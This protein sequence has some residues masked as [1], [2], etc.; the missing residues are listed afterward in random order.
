MEVELLEL[1]GLVELVDGLQSY[2]IL[3]VA[4]FVV[5]LSGFALWFP[6]R[7]ITFQT[8]S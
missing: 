2:P 8:V 7:C 4:H 5:S 6:S 3:S 1:V